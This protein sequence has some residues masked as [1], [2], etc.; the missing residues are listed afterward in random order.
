MRCNADHSLRWLVRSAGV[1]DRDAA[2][3][4]HKR[5]CVTAG[6]ERTPMYPSSG[7]VQEFSTHSTERQTLAPDTGF[8]TVVDTLH[9]RAKYAR[10]SIGAAT[11]EEHAVGVPSDGGHGGPDGLLEVLGHPPVVFGLEVADGNGAGAATDSEFGLGGRP[12]DGC[13]GTVEAEEDESGLP[14]GG[15][16]L[17]DVCIAV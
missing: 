5:E 6:R 16:R 14:A 10:M 9:E 8:W 2:V 7:I 4:C 3:V 12:A 13:G 15:S 17:P 11:C 1:D